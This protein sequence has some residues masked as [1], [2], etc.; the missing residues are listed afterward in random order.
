MIKT[1]VIAVSIQLQS[2]WMSILGAEV[3]A[4]LAETA[5]E[6]KFVKL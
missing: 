2:V 6:I 1:V 4:C 3:V 5:T